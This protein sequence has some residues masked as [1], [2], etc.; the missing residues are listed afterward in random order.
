[1]KTP[2]PSGWTMAGSRFGGQGRIQMEVYE[3]GATAWQL[4][5]CGI[6]SGPSAVCPPGQ[7]EV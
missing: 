7:M 6:G 2:P 5:C 4:G 1:M 3:P